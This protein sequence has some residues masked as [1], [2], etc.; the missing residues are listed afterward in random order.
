MRGWSLILILV[1]GTGW[2][3]Y[4]RAQ[5][6]KP[7]RP[8]T[9]PRTTS[10]RL[11]ATNVPLSSPPLTTHN[12]VLTTAVP[13]NEPEVAATVNGVKIPTVELNR[14]AQIMYEKM[15][16]RTQRLS[17]NEEN[18]LF[19]K[20]RWRLLNELIDDEVLTYEMNEAERKGE[21]VIP[22][23]GL[24]V[25]RANF[26]KLYPTEA[27]FQAAYG[28]TRLSRDDFV[29]RVHAWTLASQ[30][31]S[32]SVTVTVDEVKAFYDANPKRW[33]DQ[34]GNVLL[35]EQAQPQVERDLKSE[36]RFQKAQ[37]WLRNQRQTAPITITLSPPSR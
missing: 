29:R 26:A 2:A 10:S 13:A 15:K 22:A 33:K 37:A 24:Q 3:F 5:T 31:V 4:G 7:V 25:A 6:K 21:V 30:K 1:C 14:L 9:A 11:A 23:S 12:S 34:A 27:D 32:G 36:R 20:L 17:P 19:K 16:P 35:F 18:A 28:N 8:A